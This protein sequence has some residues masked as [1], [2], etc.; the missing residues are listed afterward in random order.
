LTFMP[1]RSRYPTQRGRLNQIT[2]LLGVPWV[3]LLVCILWRMTEDDPEL[4]LARQLTVVSLFFPVFCMTASWL[5]TVRLWRRRA[6][7]RRSVQ[8]VAG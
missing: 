6:R 1:N 4:G 5:V 2:N 3:L 7:E 8:A